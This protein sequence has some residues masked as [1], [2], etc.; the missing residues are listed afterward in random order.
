MSFLTNSGCPPNPGFGGN[1]TFDFAAPLRRRE[2]EK[3]WDLDPNTQN[4]WNTVDV[5]TEGNIGA[6]FKVL[7]PL[8]SP[9]LSSKKYLMF[10]KINIR[11]QAAPGKGVITAIVL[12]SDSGNE[13]DWVRFLKA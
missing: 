13:I 1:V 4:D 7:D 11:L 5:K 10:G 12:K 2:Y 9:T 6:A 3:F 8:V